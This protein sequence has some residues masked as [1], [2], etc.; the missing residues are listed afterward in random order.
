VSAVR[1]RDSGDII[2]P[3]DLVKDSH[4]NADSDWESAAGVREPMRVEPLETAEY[5]NGLDVA[6]SRWTATLLPGTVAKK[7]SLVR[8]HGDVYQIDGDV[9]IAY[10]GSGRP[11]HAECLL[12]KVSS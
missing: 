4:G 10:D 2:N 5:T 1:F 3:A 9:Q 8:W 6:M 7:E 12:L 11:H